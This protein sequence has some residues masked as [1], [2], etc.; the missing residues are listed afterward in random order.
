V[1]GVAKGYLWFHID[2]DTGASYW[3][4]ARDYDHL[5]RKLQI[6]RIEDNSS[7]P[8]ESPFN[9]ERYI[10]TYDIPPFVGPKD[11]VLS[12]PKAATPVGNVTDQYTEEFRIEAI[13]IGA[14]VKIISTR[15]Y[16]EQHEL[17]QALKGFCESH[18]LVSS[19]E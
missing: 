11:L 16:K 9:P 2:G 1:I 13:E 15:I 18:P 3:G 19:K 7:I 6:F 14:R 10:P 5:I 17:Q 4:E 8:T 12:K